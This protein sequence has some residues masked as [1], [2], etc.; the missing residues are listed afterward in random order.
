MC[1]VRSARQVRRGLC[2]RH[3]L[4][5][6]AGADQIGP[7]GCHSDR[8]VVAI[9]CPRLVGR[10]EKVAA[11]ARALDDAARGHGRFVVISGEAGVGK[12][13]LLREVATEAAHRGAPVL[14][15]RAAESSVS[16]FRPLTEALL[17]HLRQV[18]THNVANDPVRSALI[19]LLPG[20]AAES[21]GGGDDSVVVGE[22]VLRL[23]TTV[24]GSAGCVLGLEDLHW[25]DAETMDVVEYLADNVAG[26]PVL[27]IGTVRDDEATEQVH[28]LRRLNARRA[29]TTVPLGRLDPAAAEEMAAA[30]LGVDV[31]PAPLQQL[32]TAGAEGLPLLVEELLAV[33]D[34]TDERRPMVPVSFAET[35]RRRLRATPDTAEVLRAAAVLGR[36]F[37]EELLAAM[38]GLSDNRVATCLR[39]ALEHRLIELD[40][41]DRFRFRHALTREA[42]LTDLLPREHVGL[43]ATALT[44]VEAAH[45]GLP[46]SWCEVAA[47]LAERA[48]L[49]D[50]AARLFLEGGR[51][52]LG[53]GGLVTAETCLDRARRL[54]GEDRALAVEIND[55]LCATLALAGNNARLA[56]VGDQLLAGLV[57]VGASAARVAAAHRRLARAAVTAGDW[58]TA[59]RHLRAAAPV[60]EGAARDPEEDVLAAQVALGRDD[61]DR[62]V[63]LARQALS[64]AE[65]QGR[66]ALVCE[67]LEVIGRR[68]RTRD[69]AAAERAFAAALRTA[70]AASSEVWRVRAL[71][72]LGTIDLLSGGPIDRLAE[73]RAGALAAGTLS[74]AAT[75]GLQMAA[76]HLNH[77]EVDQ[78]VRMAREFAAEAH[79]LHLLKV[80]ALGALL[81]AGAHAL[82][83]RR[84]AMDASLADAFSLAGEDSEVRGVAALQ[85]RAA[86]WLVRE[87]R[88]RALAE[89]DAGM[90]LLR[91]TSVTAPFRG[92]W[93]LV[94]ALDHADGPAAVAAVEGSGLTSYW[95]VRGW[96]GHARAVELGR[97]GRVDEAVA[98]FTA[99]D[100]ALAGCAWYRQHARRL[101]AEAALADGWGAPTAWLADALSFFDEAGEDRIASACRALL[102]RGGATVPRRR[103]AT[104]QAPGGLQGLGLS[105]REIEVLVLLAEAR[106]TKEIAAQLFLSPK[107][108]ER[109]VA[110]VA[111]KVGVGGRAELIAFAAGRLLREEQPKREP[112]TGP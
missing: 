19:R 47:T 86:Y 17:S 5:R 18:E 61:P 82:A 32:L 58:P 23:L 15:G 75:V 51:R 72:E 109:H 68:E 100:E 96:V 27:V 37:D 97:A 16:P 12:S 89:L 71:H 40:P 74:T 20:W 49:A 95:L 84:T 33:A 44:A 34:A 70:Q 59:E 6:P 64:A 76:W 83:G 85:V 53:R 60:G 94:H 108:V 7:F 87:D 28:R 38:T 43:A 26:E 77:A 67:A 39:T 102:R 9:P 4:R 48:G 22:A 3:S 24:A 54:S 101:V 2:T 107:T 42:I 92:M 63:D 112:P 41:D 36:D 104:A 73:A 110:N 13:R 69:L 25:A 103:R 46:G 10:D 14:V 93:A 80:E 99:A 57:E 98:A 65:P 1:Q 78:T 106:P 88:V 90:E 105:P 81:E 66:P 62:A 50:R 8:V 11:L 21:V 52:A 29:V 31:V 79:R 91:G 30:C 55:A 56:E 111:A 35:V 45:P